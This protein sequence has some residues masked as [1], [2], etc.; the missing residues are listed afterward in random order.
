MFQEASF[1]GDLQDSKSASGGGLC[2]YG[3]HTFATM[4]WLCKKQPVV[5]HSNAEAEV[6]FLTL[7]CEWNVVGLCIGCFDASLKFQEQLCAALHS[8]YS[9][10]KH[11]INRLF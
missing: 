10:I 9:T 7:E 3:D 5:S 1:A 11:S 2:I 4:S 8:T 6:M